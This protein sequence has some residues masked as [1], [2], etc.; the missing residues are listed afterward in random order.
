M[1]QKNKYKIPD[2]PNADEVLNSYFQ[3]RAKDTHNIRQII[4][5]TLVDIG[6]VPDPVKLP[7]VRSCSHSLIISSNP[8]AV[9]SWQE[10]CRDLA[11]LAVVH[12][13]RE[14]R[15]DLL[16]TSPYLELVAGPWERDRPPAVPQTLLDRLLKLM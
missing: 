1:K 2:L 15:C 7:V 5:L 9:P 12:S 4:D 6:G 14:K 11:P 16:Q 8:Q 10:L 13:V 3:E